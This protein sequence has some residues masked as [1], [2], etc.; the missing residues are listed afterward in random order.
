[1]NDALT[2]EE[3]RALPATID[4]PT[5]A[6]AL[7]LGRT[8]AYELAKRDQFPCRILRIGSTYRIPTAELLH[9]LG[10]GLSS[11]SST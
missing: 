4:L 9:C 10:M 8:K 2:L 3:L 5:A 11:D 6:R 7:G 1:M